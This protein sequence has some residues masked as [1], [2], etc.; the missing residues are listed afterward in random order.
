MDGVVGLF[1]VL[2]NYAKVLQ[3]VDIFEKKMSRHIFGNKDD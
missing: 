2:I 1:I 3:L